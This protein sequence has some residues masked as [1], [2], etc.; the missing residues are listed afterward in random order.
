[1]SVDHRNSFFLSA[2]QHEKQNANL[3]NIGCAI[4][5]NS[6]H[7]IGIDTSSAELIHAI[8]TEVAY[9]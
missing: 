2:G 8:S 7:L 1:M 3:L 9:G 6:G 4:L 5:Q